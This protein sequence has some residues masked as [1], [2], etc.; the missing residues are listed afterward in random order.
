MRALALVILAAGLVAT[1]A[2]AA[3]QAPDDSWFHVPALVITHFPDRGRRPKDLFEELSHDS[4]IGKNGK[5]VVYDDKRGFV[6]VY[7]RILQAQRA[8]PGLSSRS[9]P[10]RLPSWHPDRSGAGMRG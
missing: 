6:T 9:P 1:L 2:A 3:F 4:G 5:V 10:C 7:E 8:W